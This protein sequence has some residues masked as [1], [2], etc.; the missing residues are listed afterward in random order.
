ML[1]P[2]TK[3]LIEAARFANSDEVYGRLAGF[4]S[5]WDYRAVG[6]L[7]RSQT[8]LRPYG[9]IEEALDRRQDLAQDGGA[10]G[11][12][13]RHEHGVIGAIDLDYVLGD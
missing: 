6:R 5:R 1:D 7:Q 12:R 9:M 3:T 13:S 2:V 8:V 4:A 10:G 11:K